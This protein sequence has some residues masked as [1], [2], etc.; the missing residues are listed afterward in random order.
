MFCIFANIL[1]ATEN[2]HENTNSQNRKLY[3]HA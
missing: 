2:K 3:G 1:Q